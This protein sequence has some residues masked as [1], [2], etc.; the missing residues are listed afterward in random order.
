MKP[1]YVWCI[2][3]KNAHWVKKEVCLIMMTNPKIRCPQRCSERIKNRDKV[4]GNKAKR[5]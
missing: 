2:R 1:G 4:N 3:G 5:N